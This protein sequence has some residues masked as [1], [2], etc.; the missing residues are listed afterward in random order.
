MWM[1]GSGELVNDFI[2]GAEACHLPAH[3]VGHVVGDDGM[4]K[5]EM[6]CNILLEEL[7][8]LLP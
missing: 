1:V 3:E 4:R 7:D 5:S 6:T 8:Y 2:I